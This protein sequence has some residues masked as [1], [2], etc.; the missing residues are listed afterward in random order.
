M[1]ITRSGN[2]LALYPSGDYKVYSDTNFVVGDS[3]V[4]LDARTDLGHDANNGYINCFGPGSILIKITKGASGVADDQFTLNAGDVANIMG[5]GVS[6]ITIT[7][8][9]TDSAYEVFVE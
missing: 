7:H 9:G 6:K 5:E 8:S 1:S 3:P 2:G 4:V